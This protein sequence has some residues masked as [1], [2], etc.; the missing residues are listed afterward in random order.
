MSKMLCSKLVLV[1][2]LFFTIEEIVTD[3]ADDF[4]FK[5]IFYR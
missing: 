1:G 3:D 2:F 4:L 5:T